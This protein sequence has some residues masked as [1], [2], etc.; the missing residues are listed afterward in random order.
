VVAGV[1]SKGRRDALIGT[2]LTNKEKKNREMAKGGKG[3]RF[4][5]ARIAGKAASKKWGVQGGGERSKRLNGNEKRPNLSKARQW[6]GTT[7]KNG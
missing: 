4:F 7:L 1:E 5:P 2:M 3:A 6:E